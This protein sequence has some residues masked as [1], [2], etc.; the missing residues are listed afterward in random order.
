[1]N[2][3]RK[4]GRND[5]DGYIMKGLRFSHGKGRWYIKLFGSLNL[6]Y[7]FPGACKFALV[8]GS[9]YRKLP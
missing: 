9:L 2:E 3:L 1:M 6:L 4:E 5:R 8:K 7:R